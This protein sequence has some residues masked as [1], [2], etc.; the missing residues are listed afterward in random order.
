MKNLVNKEV[1]PIQHITSPLGILWMALSSLSFAFMSFFTKLMYMNSDI[2]PFE[3]VYLRGVSIVILN[4]IYS[5]VINVD[6]L[7]IPEHLEFTLWIRIFIGNIGICLNSLANKLLPI[8]I[9]NSLFY[10]Y[11]IITGCGGFI[12]LKEKMSI[13]EIV[14]MFTAFIGVLLIILS[15]QNDSKSL[16]KVPIYYY[17]PPIIAAFTSSAVHLITRKMGC[18]VHFLI[19]PT[20]LGVVQA[21]M[22]APVWLY[23]RSNGSAWMPSSSVIFYT[24]MACLGSWLG[25]IFMNKSLQIEKAG[26]V[27]AVGFLQI[28]ILFFCDLFYFKLS[29]GWAVILGS[30][31]IIMCSLIAGILRLLNKLD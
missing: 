23:I 1:L 4:Y 31:L 20:W 14:G 11:P 8:S 25:Q 24:C 30:I 15:S 13:L 26:R 21:I 27:A 19:N 22:L 3:A 5:K 28:P 9:A 7:K 12:F 10:I 6:I 18:D 2:N 29:I 16:D 17:T